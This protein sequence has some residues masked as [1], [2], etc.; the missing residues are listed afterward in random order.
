MP[1]RSSRPIFGNES[2]KAPFTTEDDYA[3]ILGDSSEEKGIDEIPLTSI[4]T[5]KEQRLQ[6]DQEEEEK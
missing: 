2:I 4:T 6:V 1:S 5:K 3:P